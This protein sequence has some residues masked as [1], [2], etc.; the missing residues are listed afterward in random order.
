[1]KPEIDEELCIAVQA[2]AWLMRLEE[3]GPI[4]HEELSVWLMQSARHVRA[5]LCASAMSQRLDGLDPQGR[6]DVEALI[7]EAKSLPEPHI[8]DYLTQA[9]SEI[10]RED[11]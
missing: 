2:A 5:F 7:E 11:F 8:D 6:I 3:E 9:F 4:C 10:C 1:M